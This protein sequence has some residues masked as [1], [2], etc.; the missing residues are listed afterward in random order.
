MVPETD[1]RNLQS[2]L[3][4]TITL[5]CRNS[6]LQCT[7]RQIN[8][9]IGV[10]LQG[11]EVVLI[12]IN[13][14]DASDDREADHFDDGLQSANG[15]VRT[16]LAKGWKPKTELDCED[17]ETHVQVRSRKKRK[18][19][20]N[21][22]A[23][24]V[25]QEI[26]SQEI[27]SESDDCRLIEADEEQSLLK[28]ESDSRTSHPYRE[29]IAADDCIQWQTVGGHETGDDILEGSEPDD[30]CKP[31]ADQW[32]TGFQ[33]FESSASGSTS[34]SFKR[35]VRGRV[36]ARTQRR[37][38]MGRRNFSSYASVPARLEVNQ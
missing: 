17:A 31:S 33:H 34:R 8:A 26:R 27:D 11:G 9:L 13:E 35:F 38:L 25:K 14:T 29:S 18:R 32:I 21:V 4:D 20:F 23:A 7:I 36:A 6:L 28:F 19:S 30:D 2:L 1:R 3:T 22:E 12:T 5:M 15:E 24:E 37:L 10:T 16:Q